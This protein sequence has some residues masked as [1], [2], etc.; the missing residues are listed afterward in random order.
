MR[1]AVIGGGPA[2]AEAA[3]R[4]AAGGAQTILFD[5]S[6]DR[7]KP[8][9]GG[10][11][12]RGLQEF[13]GLLGEGIPAA[14]IHH[15]HFEG[16]SG[17]SASIK[18][19]APLR[20]FSRRT[21]DSHW[22]ERAGRCG[23]M[24]RR[25]KIVS[26]SRGDRFLLRTASG[27]QQVF[28]FVVGADGARSLMRATFARP[29]APE[30]LS[31]AVGYYVPGRTDD[32][33]RLAF[34]EDLHGY[35]WSFPRLD[36]LAVGAC[37]PL[38]PRSAARLRAAVERYLLRLDPGLD[39]SALPYYSALIPCLSSAS[40]ARDCKAGPGWCLV[41]DA[42][43]AVDPLTREGIYYGLKSAALAAGAILR[44]RPEEY[45]DDWQAACGGELRWASQRSERFFEPEL[46]DRLVR[47]LGA[48]AAVRK[49]MV[50]LV[51]G[52]QSYLTLKRRLLASAPAAAIEWVVHGW[53]F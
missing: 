53:R 14:D 15:V 25:E 52:R 20:V 37:A 26:V 34:R 18:L 29:F 49:V 30:D 7:E 48:S 21:L 42:A 19:P 45:P 31:Q 27:D 46:T 36:H 5:P 51:L 47:L 16:P 43:G 28:D 35:L 39:P 3:S 11:P 12:W 13:D 17:G 33:L 1:I 4:L 10:I 2:G 44:G 24:L 6:F 22:A 32:T 9:G 41:G 40:Q 50:D 23:A 38:A 8:C